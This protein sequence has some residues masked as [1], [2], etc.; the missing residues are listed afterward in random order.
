MSKP[1]IML[2]IPTRGTLRVELV[3]V[4]FKYVINKD[5]YD[6]EINFVTGQPV[7]DARNKMVKKFLESDN[8]WLLMIDD[9]VVPPDNAIEVML[10]HGKKVIG[11]LC[12]TSQGVGGII[13]LVMKRNEVGYEIDPRVGVVKGLLEVDGLGT[14]CL[15][16][17]RSVIKKIKKPLFNFE[18]DADGVVSCGEDFNFCRKAKNAGFGIFVDTTLICRHF[19]CQDLLHVNYALLR[20]KE[21]GRMSKGGD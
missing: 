19:V 3:T 10:G 8:E 5:L 4:L 11:S 6:A 15:M 13:P 17:H 16:I 2:C 21:E 1:K 7:D 18:Y 9:D 14:G 12:F 20:A